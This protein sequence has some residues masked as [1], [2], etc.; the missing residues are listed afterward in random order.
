MHVQVWAWGVG[1]ER[2]Q[3]EESNYPSQSR[4]S[5]ISQPRAVEQSF[6][7]SEPQFPQPV[8][9]K[10]LYPNEVEGMKH[11]AMKYLVLSG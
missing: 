6:L 1:K 3:M 10:Y 11:L 7:L 9:R 4:G 5:T 2:T 8:T